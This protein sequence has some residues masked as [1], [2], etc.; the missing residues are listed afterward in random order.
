VIATAAPAKHNAVRALGA[1]LVLDS[2]DPDLAAELLALARGVDLV[3]ESVGRTTFTASLAATKPITGRVIVFG[4]SSGEAALS[5]HN[6]VFT[7]PVQVKGLHIGVLADTAPAVY[8]SLLT[9]LQELVAQG[10]YPPGRPQLHPLA[11][12]PAVLRDVEARRTSG[13]QALDPW[14]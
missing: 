10:V 11:D 2:T 6:L 1:D 5:T 8:R 4:A 13:K 3:L 7:H 9:E 12:G 14:C